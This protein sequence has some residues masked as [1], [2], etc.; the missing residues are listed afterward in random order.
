MQDIL[1]QAASELTS[2]NK[3]DGRAVHGWSK[4]YR[5]QLEKA[6]M[7]Y[8]EAFYAISNLEKAGR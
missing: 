3:T 4:R 6:G 5:N 7:S 1:N 8:N 2:L